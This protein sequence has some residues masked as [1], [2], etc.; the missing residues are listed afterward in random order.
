MNVDKKGE[1]TCRT[2]VSNQT[3]DGQSKERRVVPSPCAEST[4]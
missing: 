2:R 1:E 4:F 3:S